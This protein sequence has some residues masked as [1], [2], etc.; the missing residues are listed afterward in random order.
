MEN[1]SIDLLNSACA[2]L[3]GSKD[4]E[5]FPVN[6]LSRRPGEWV[7]VRDLCARVG[8]ASGNIGGE[9][10]ALWLPDPGGDP[11]YV[12]VLFYDVESLWT[13]AAAY[14]GERLRRPATTNREQPADASARV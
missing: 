8:V 9:V 13:L 2:D 1:D 3:V 7:N 6:L 12:V 4:H 10:F 14:N 5:A 11:S